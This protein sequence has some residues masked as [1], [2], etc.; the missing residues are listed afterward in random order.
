VASWSVAFTRKRKRVRCHESW[1]PWH[2]EA[3]LREERAFERARPEGLQIR[4]L[5]GCSSEGTLRRRFRFSLLQRSRAGPLFFQIL[6][7]AM[8]PSEG[9]GLYWHER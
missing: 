2:S 4:I 8:N 3:L 5:A 9:V 6:R 1:E 7:R